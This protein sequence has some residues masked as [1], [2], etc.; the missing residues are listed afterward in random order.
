MIFNKE[1][2]DLFSCLYFLILTSQNV[3]INDPMYL[4]SR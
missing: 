2:H 4:G 1:T 3:L